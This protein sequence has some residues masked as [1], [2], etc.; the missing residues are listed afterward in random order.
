M[1]RLKQDFDTD[2]GIIVWETKKN[3]EEELESLGEK[4]RS[5]FKSNITFLMLVE[6]CAF[7]GNGKCINFLQTTDD[8]FVHRF[9]GFRFNTSFL[10]NCCDKI[11]WEKHN[12]ANVLLW[13][14]RG[15]L[16]GIEYYSNRYLVACKIPKDVSSQKL[17][18]G[19]KE[20]YAKMAVDKFLRNHDYFVGHI[21]TRQAIDLLLA[22]NLILTKERLWKKSEN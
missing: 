21:N 10:G 4:F 3:T 9:G 15:L 1:Y 16:K 6:W 18:K 13:K 12:G 20:I 14:H 7:N 17:T 19:Q 2:N 22:E 8:P 5:V 11:L